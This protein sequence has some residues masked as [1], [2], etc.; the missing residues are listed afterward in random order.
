[1]VLQT[2]LRALL[3]SRGLDH[4]DASSPTDHAS[5]NR[6]PCCNVVL[7]GDHGFPSFYRGRVVLVGGITASVGLE[8]AP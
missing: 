1:M 4:D 7:A 2:T 8:F 5:N 6:R 3:C